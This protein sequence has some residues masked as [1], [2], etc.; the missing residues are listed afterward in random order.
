MYLMFAWSLSLSICLFLKICCVLFLFP[1][2][3]FDR[4]IDGWWVS[5][6]FS[7]DVIHYGYQL[8]HFN[9]S[10]LPQNVKIYFNLVIRPSLHEKKNSI[11]GSKML[12]GLWERCYFY[13][14]ISKYTVHSRIPGL[15]RI[16]LDPR[17]LLDQKLFH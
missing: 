1:D 9:Y 14:S 8:A 7:H 2:Q 4:W 11:L 3:L 16:E 12:H 15:F 13:L 5:S 6:I 17:G 10:L